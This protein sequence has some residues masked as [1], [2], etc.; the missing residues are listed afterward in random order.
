MIFFFSLRAEVMRQVTLSTSIYKL[1]QVEF[2]PQKRICEF[3]RQILKKRSVFGAWSKRSSEETSTAGDGGAVNAERLFTVQ[4]SIEMRPL[5]RGHD[6]APEVSGAAA[7]RCHRR[8]R[9]QAWRAWQ[10]WAWRRRCSLQ[11]TADEEYIS[12]LVHKIR[13]TVAGRERWGCN[14][15][16]INQRRLASLVFSGERK[17]TIASG[18]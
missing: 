8:G 10:V 3:E 12:R 9:W 5:I 15:L 14:A 6:S 7:R 16:L 17:R 18:G 1:S 13:A 4:R 2:N 11:V